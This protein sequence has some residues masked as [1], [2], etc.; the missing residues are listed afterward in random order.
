MNTT[1]VFSG[2]YTSSLQIEQRT[3]FQIKILCLIL[4]LG[5]IFHLQYVL[6][7]LSDIK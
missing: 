7:L 3:I 1:Q 4:Q 2:I 6:S 5:L